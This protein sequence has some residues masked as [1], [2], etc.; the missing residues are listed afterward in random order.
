MATTDP[1]TDHSCLIPVDDGQEGHAGHDHRTFL[2]AQM[3]GAPRPHVAW[4]LPLTRGTIY[5]ADASEFKGIELSGRGSGAYRLVLES[6]G[7]TGDQWFAAPFAP[8]GEGKPERIPF[9]AFVSADPAAKLDLTQ[10]RALRVMLR[11][12]SGKTA[13]LELGGIAFYR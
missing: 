1:G 2:A 4:V 3:G 5:V 11:G 8:T 12:E 9:S 7:L 13:S 10:L 6:Y